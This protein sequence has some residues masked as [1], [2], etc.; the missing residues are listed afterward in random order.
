MAAHFKQKIQP[1]TGQQQIRQWKDRIES[2]EKVA[3]T[4]KMNK[5][6]R[7]KKVLTSSIRRSIDKL[8]EALLLIVKTKGGT[9]FSIL[10]HCFLD[11]D[12]DR[13]GE[14]AFDEFRNAMAKLGVRFSDQECRDIV[15]YYDVDGDG[16]MRYEPLV[17]EVMKG[18]KHWMEHP[19]TPEIK[20]ETE[21]RR[22]VNVPAFMMDKVNKSNSN[23]PVSS[24]RRSG[25]GSDSE[26]SN[27]SER[28]LALSS[29]RSGFDTNRR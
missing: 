7:R 1:S 14:L 5:R 9:E 4:D 17:V 21:K 20:A 8:R 13:S 25:M 23:S 24:S 26:R 28:S 15:E 22:N 6:G 11:W 2:E 12:A 27:G 19:S 3:F 29:S 16:E 18:A 10:R